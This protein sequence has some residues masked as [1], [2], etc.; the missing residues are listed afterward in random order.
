MTE[1]QIQ[2]EELH[3]SMCLLLEVHSWILGHCKATDLAHRREADFSIVFSCLPVPEA[4]TVYGT[5]LRMP[6]AR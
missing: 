5:R 2:V 1:R 3:W 4:V 6:M